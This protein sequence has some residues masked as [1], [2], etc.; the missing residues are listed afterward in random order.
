M[1]RVILVFGGAAGLVLLLGSGTFVGGLIGSAVI[2]WLLYA[3]AKA[4]PKRLSPFELGRAARITD[5]KAKARAS[6]S[7]KTPN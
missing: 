3:N 5:S 2:V 4:D 6:A 7:N 1:L